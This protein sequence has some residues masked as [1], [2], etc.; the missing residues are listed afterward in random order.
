M[1]GPNTLSAEVSY[2]LLENTKLS[3]SLTNLLPSPL[4]PE[5]GDKGGRLVFEGTPKNCSKNKLSYTGK[6]L[7]AFFYSNP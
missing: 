1:L 3:V 4:T 7:E 6:F 2:F 5:G